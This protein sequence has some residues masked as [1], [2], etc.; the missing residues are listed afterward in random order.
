MKSFFVDNEGIAIHVLESGTP[1]TGIPSLLVIG[2]IWDPAERAIPIHN[3]ESHVVSFS[4]RGRGLSS[5]PEFGYDLED[6]LSDIR[7]VVKACALNDYCVLGFSRGAAY[8]LGWYLT[9]ETR[10]S[11]LI[12]VDQAPIHRKI[13]F[14]S[15]NFWCNMVYQEVPVANYMRSEAFVGLSRDAI[16]RDF[17]S[18][19]VTIDCPVRLFVGTSSQSKMPSGLSAESMAKYTEN[20]KNISFVE[21]E[22]SGHMIPDEDTEKYLEEIQQFIET[23]K[24]KSN[25]AHLR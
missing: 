16:E 5:T 17:T 7:E 6:H 20:V 24:E 1:K 13:P 3:L 22:K 14:E 8:T 12:L 25:D 19:L 18:E 15:L 2:G 23:L 9:K 10:I 4:F 11:G 21:F